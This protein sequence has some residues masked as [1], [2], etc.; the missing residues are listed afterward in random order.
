MAV[1][2]LNVIKQYER[3]VLFTFGSFTEVR[4]PGIRWIWPFINNGSTT[5]DLREVPV[6]IPSQTSITRDNAPINIDFFVY[7]RVME[8]RPEDTI[9]NI[10]DYRSAAQALAM[11]TLRAVVGE[12]DLDDV[13]SKRERIN[14]ALQTK[15]DEVTANWGVKVTRVEIKEVEPPRDVQDAMNRQLSAERTRRAAVTEAEGQRDAEI[16]RAEGER[17]SSILRAEGTKQAAILEAEGEQQ[18]QILRADGFSD[19]MTR[20]NAVASQADPRT[21][22]L[23][24]FET[25]KEMGAGASTKFIFPLEF[26]S[27]LQ[28]FMNNM[29]SSTDG[30]SDS[31]S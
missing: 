11:T 30:G 23:Q 2:G 10:S 18:A 27:L 31:N 5:V 13:L 21:M 22:S 4:Q 9:L 1:W 12:M 16:N 6:A 3:L 19:A 24:Y 29:A 17:R 7:M 15:L 28:P 20:I 8:D 26:T 14:G 25:L